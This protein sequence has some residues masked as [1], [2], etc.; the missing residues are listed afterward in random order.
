MPT[1]EPKK[2]MQSLLNKLYEVITG[3]IED[4]PV[5]NDNY[6]TWITPGIPF[7][8]DFFDFASLPITSASAEDRASL[9]R[10]Y[11]DNANAW[12]ILSNFVPSGQ[13]LLMSPDF[14]QAI[15]HTS[16]ELLW[17]IFDETLRMSKVAVAQLSEE[18]KAKVER[19]RNLLSVKKEKEN[20][21]TGEKQQ[22][23]E[24]GP[25]YIAYKQ[26]QQAYLAAAF[27]YKSAQ[28]SFNNAESTEAV[29]EFRF[30][31]NELRQAVRT[32]YDDWVTNGY[33]NEVEQMIAYIDQVTQRDMASIKADIQDK[34][35]AGLQTGSN[36]DFYYTS[37]IPG[38]FM[39]STGWSKFEFS[40]GSYSSYSRE[41]SSAWQGNAGFD[42]GFWSS[43]GN[44]NS[45]TASS[46]ASFDSNG[47]TIK[48]EITQVPIARGWFDPGFIIGKGWKWSGE[49][50]GENLS[51]GEIP[52]SGRL[53]AYP[54][55][56]L[57]V[58]KVLINSNSFQ[59]DR[60]TYENHLNSGGSIGWGPF[61]I[62][63]NYSR[64]EANGRSSW[65]FDNEG[66][67]IDDLQ[68]I[69]FICRF[70]GKAPNPSDRAQFD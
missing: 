1:V 41:D 21:V 25:V 22:V 59:S 65:H 5:D 36:G 69:G 3:S 11:A 30:M 43:G 63:G 20:L 7:K 64:N 6:V 58:R 61:S 17:N 60:S 33:K 37:V 31:G 9:A 49:Y 8:Q 66:L 57:F 32:A 35:R 14:R 39:N 19:Y 53:V 26:K 70:T 10:R 38:D 68:L 45:S 29:N 51:N 23:T 34:F 46:Y 4:M 47:F 13:P 54:T 16:Q 12:A 44:M 24:D 50:T 52:P 2:L 55:A 48:F 18:E 15:Y 67:H 56:A 27:K 28:I 40:E 62:G 42:L